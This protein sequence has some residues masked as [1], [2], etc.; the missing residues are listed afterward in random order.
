[1]LFE[2]RKEKP[3]TVGSFCSIKKDVLLKM[4]ETKYYCQNSLSLYLKKYGMGI[5]NSTLRDYKQYKI[6]VEDV[7]FFVAKKSFIPGHLDL[8][9]LII[10]EDS[11]HG[12]GIKSLIDK[13]VFFTVSSKI[14]KMETSEYTKHQCGEVYSGGVMSYISRVLESSQYYNTD[15][16]W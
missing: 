14:M 7:P 3:A 12:T 16:E 2:R 10:N 5:Y 6:L 4:K 13:K 9:P 15:I 1:M 11:I 8:I